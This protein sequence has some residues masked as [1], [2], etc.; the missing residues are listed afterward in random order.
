[1][2]GVAVY[3]VFGFIIFVPLGFLIGFL[4]HQQDE[5]QERENN[6]APFSGT[7]DDDDH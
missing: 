3:L 6:Q 4:D 2:T 5:K 1:M 7:E